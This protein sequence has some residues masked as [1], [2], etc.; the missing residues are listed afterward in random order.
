MQGAVAEHLQLYT[1]V[2]Y[3]DTV[4]AYHVRLKRVMRVLMVLNCQ[5]PNKPRYV[6]LFSSD[7]EL[8]GW[9]IYR[10]YN[11][12]RAFRSSSYFA[13]PSSGPGCATAK[14]VM[15]KPCTFTSTPP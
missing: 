9:D 13:M 2:A 7:V 4:V 3:H 8:G 14:R 12:K 6:L 11:T 1:V 15:Q 10:Y 5:D